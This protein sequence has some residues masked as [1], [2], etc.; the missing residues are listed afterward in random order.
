MKYILN[1]F[2][3]CMPG[4]LLLAQKDTTL[5]YLNMDYKKTTKDSAYSFFKFYKQDNNWHGQ[6]F[7]V[8]DNIIKSDVNYTDS[9]LTKRTDMTKYY[10]DDG[11]LDFTGTF[12]NDT[13]LDRTYY[14]K[15]GQKK[16][17]ILYKPKGASE[18][19]GWDVDGKEIEGFIVEQEARFPGGAQG[20][21]NYL[22]KNLNYY[23]WKKWKNL[24]N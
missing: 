23:R 14:Y 6:E 17:Y 22:I 12:R 21:Q 10:K 16:S 5:V 11:T 13:L 2:V 4:Q 20:W 1:L 7:Y 18:A 15:T 8:K 3:F 19:K 9:T 24:L